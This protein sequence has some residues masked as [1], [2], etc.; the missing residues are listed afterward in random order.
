MIKVCQTSCFC[1]FCTK[2]HEWTFRMSFFSSVHYSSLSIC[3]TITVI[4]SHSQRLHSFTLLQCYSTA[5]H[6]VDQLSVSFNAIFLLL[7]VIYH[8]NLHFQKQR[9]FRSTNFIFV[10][11]TLSYISEPDIPQYLNKKLSYCWET[12]RRESMPRIAEMDMEMTT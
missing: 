12:V 3:C 6:T 11:W 4:I 8:N 1:I 10:M 9:M 2:L 7:F 5:C